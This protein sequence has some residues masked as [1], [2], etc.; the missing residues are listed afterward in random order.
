MKKK[1]LPE[2]YRLKPIPGHTYMNPD[3]T[4]APPTTFYLRTSYPK[5]GG[6]DIENITVGAGRKHYESE[7]KLLDFLDKVNIR[8]YDVAEMDTLHF[9]LKHRWYT[10]IESDGKREEYRN[11]TEYWTKR[12]T[13]NTHTEVSHIILHWRTEPLDF[14]H[15]DLVTFHDGYTRRTQTWTVADITLGKGNPAWGAP[16]HQVFIIKLGERVD[17]HNKNEE[18]TL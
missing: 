14:K 3:G 9:V 13:K 2:H 11:P 18:K 8:S 15:Y 17:T 7:G 10:S 5:D 4:A 6:I 16:E 1:K 12:L